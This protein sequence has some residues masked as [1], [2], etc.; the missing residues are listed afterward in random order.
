MSNFQGWTTERKV[1][2]PCLVKAHTPEA[3]LLRRAC[4]T[5]AV[6]LSGYGLS[7]TAHCQGA[8][9]TGMKASAS[10]QLLGL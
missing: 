6:C 3:M 7:C 9:L 1:S 2:F 10:C 8:Q 4:S 5:C